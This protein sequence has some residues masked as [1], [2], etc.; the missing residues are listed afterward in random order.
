[1]ATSATSIDL[2]RKTPFTVRDYRQM[3][4]DGRRYEVID[5]ILLMAPA[6][7]RYHQRISRNLCRIVYQFLHEHPIGE[8]YDAPFDV[9]F[10]DLN[11]VQPDLVFVANASREVLAPEGVVGAPDLVAEILS[12]GTSKRDLRD[13][14]DL[15][16]KSGVKEFW[17]LS[18]EE[19]QVQ[20][21]L[22]EVDRIKPA[23]ILAEGETLETPLL[24][25]LK[26][27]VAELFEQ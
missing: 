12:P 11:V 26:I 16:A 19:H 15:Y 4:E 23:R 21:Y 2:P 14:R 24:A 7:N 25:G 22:P 13:K 27:L 10:D 6:P 1:M 18:P 3:P 9:Y 20:V 5:G 8:A 17:M